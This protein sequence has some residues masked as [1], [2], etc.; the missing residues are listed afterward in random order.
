MHYYVYKCDKHECPLCYQGN[1]KKNFKQVVCFKQLTSRIRES[2]K[3]PIKLVNYIYPKNLEGRKRLRA[4]S[5]C[6]LYQKTFRHTLY[7]N[8][9]IFFYFIY[10]QSANSSPS[11]PGTALYH[12][13]GSILKLASLPVLVPRFFFLFTSFTPIF[14][15]IVRWFRLCRLSP[16]HWY[17]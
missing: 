16:F 5:Q 2:Q 15:F 7:T 6:I 17:T 10:F 14:K 1:L 8:F 12:F 11:I 13:A 9:F 4:L 3:L